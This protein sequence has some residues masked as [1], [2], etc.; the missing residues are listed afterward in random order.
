[1][2]EWLH[3]EGIGSYIDAAAESADLDTEVVMKN[4][5]GC[6]LDL[7]AVEIFG[8]DTS[9]LGG[10]TAAELRGVET[11][12]GAVSAGVSQRPERLG[13]VVPAGVSVVATTYKRMKGRELNT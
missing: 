5:Q 3:S 6:C 2:V 12:Q 8:G 9:E 4:H 1:V 7:E 10:G 13:S 11:L